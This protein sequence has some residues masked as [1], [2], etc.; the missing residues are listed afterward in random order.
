[1]LAYRFHWKRKVWAYF[2]EYNDYGARSCQ[3][4]DEFCVIVIGR[5]G[6][7]DGSPLLGYMPVRPK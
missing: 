1:M 6:N 4:D 5:P 3:G 7:V 2:R